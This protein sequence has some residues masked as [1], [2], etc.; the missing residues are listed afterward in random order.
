MHNR[1]TLSISYGYSTLHHR[2]PSSPLLSLFA[3]H[4]CE[5]HCSHP[6]YALESRKWRTP[7]ENTNHSSKA[8]YPLRKPTTHPFPLITHGKRHALLEMLLMKDYFL[9][10]TIRLRFHKPIQIANHNTL[11]TITPS[12]PSSRSSSQ[13]PSC[14]QKPFHSSPSRRQQPSSC[15]IS[16]ESEPPPQSQ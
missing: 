3:I 7:I 11:K 2:T 15:A 13:H 4:F 12:Q 6:N 8:L 16:T 1:I 14:Y 5:Y 10:N 9:F